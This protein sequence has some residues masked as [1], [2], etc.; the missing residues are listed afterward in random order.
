MYIE[1]DNNT[2]IRSED[3]DINSEELSKDDDLI[4]DIKLMFIG[5]NYNTLCQLNIIYNLVMHYFCREK[6]QKGLFEEHECPFKKKSQLQIINCEKE[7]SFVLP[8]VSNYCN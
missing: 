3:I 6:C 1:R 8:W 7:K 5:S 2:I 4:A